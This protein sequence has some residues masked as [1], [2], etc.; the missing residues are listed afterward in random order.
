MSPIQSLVDL[1]HLAHKLLPLL[2][3]LLL[4]LL[5]LAF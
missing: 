3:E 2:L 5:L 1:G 4:Q